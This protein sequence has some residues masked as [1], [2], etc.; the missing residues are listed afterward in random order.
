MIGKWMVTKEGSR[1]VLDRKE[2]VEKVFEAIHG[3]LGHY[4]KDTMDLLHYRLEILNSC[5]PCQ[6]FMCENPVKASLHPFGICMEYGPFE[7]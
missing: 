4:G 1:T 6:L 7:F 3:D 5:I 2:L